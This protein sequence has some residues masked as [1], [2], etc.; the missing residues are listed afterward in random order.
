MS[1]ERLTENIDVKLRA[2]GKLMWSSHWTKWKPR[3]LLSKGDILGPLTAPHWP[4]KKAQDAHPDHCLCQE[5]FQEHL[6][7]QHCC[8]RRWSYHFC[9]PQQSHWLMKFKA[10]S[11]LKDFHLVPP[12]RWLTQSA[13]VREHWSWRTPSHLHQK[14]NLILSLD[15]LIK[16]NPWFHLD[17]CGITE[18]RVGMKIWFLSKLIFHFSGQ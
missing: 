1:L 5:H 12:K 18:R 3:G 2:F 16:S 14:K 15:T 8:Q 7:Q 10:S 13:H 9:M 4:G 11:T 6:P 17:F